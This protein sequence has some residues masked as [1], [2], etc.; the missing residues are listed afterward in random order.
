MM[1]AL[2]VVRVNMV[3][4]VKPTPGL[5]TKS[6][7]FCRLSAMPR[8]WMAIDEA[9]ERA[10]VLFKELLEFI[11]IDPGSWNVAAQ[12]VYRQQPK[13]EQNSLAQVGNTENIG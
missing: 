13:S 9:Q 10:A 6:P 12:A 1:K 5:T 3:I 8:D 4:N 2:P 7:P 11:G